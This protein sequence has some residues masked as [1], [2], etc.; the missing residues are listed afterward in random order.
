MELILPTV[1]YQ[2]S[3]FAYIKELGD[4]ERYPFP[5]DFEHKDFVGLLNKID[6]YANG[7]DIPDDAVPSSTYWLMENAEIIGV[8]NLRHCLN[9]QIEFCGGHIGL[10]VRPSCRGKGVGNILMEKS[11]H[12]LNSMGVKVVH[13]HCYKSN[14]ASASMIIANGGALE[15][16]FSDHG[17]V[18][19]R[20]VVSTT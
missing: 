16:E 14:L 1:Q 6:N 15:S 17:K 3:Y 8:T 11:I 5:V 4:E 13:I 9:Q 19:Q 18:I 10:G 12:Q 20:F 2:E 7:I